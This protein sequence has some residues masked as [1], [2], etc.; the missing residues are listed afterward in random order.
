[1]AIYRRDRHLSTTVSIEEISYVK[2]FKDKPEALKEE[3]R[4]ILSSHRSS[5]LDTDPTKFLYKMWSVMRE[6]MPYLRKDEPSCAKP[7]IVACRSAKISRFDWIRGSK[8][9]GFTE[10]KPEDVLTTKVVSW[11]HWFH[12]IIH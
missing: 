8:I 3:H 1:M 12:K 9:S 6:T 7:I 2:L 5:S 4:R 10:I 11:M